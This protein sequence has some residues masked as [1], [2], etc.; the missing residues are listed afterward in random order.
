M[1]HI[2]ARPQN[3]VA[4]E[5]IDDERAWGRQSGPCCSCH[6]PRV[7]LSTSSPPGDH[8]GQ[9]EHDD[10]N[11]RVQSQWPVRPGGA[12]LDSVD[13]LKQPP[14]HALPYVVD[15]SVPALSQLCASMPPL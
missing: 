15:G 3:E 14:I 4:D 6:S 2:G 7:T 13:P 1:G 10:A 11:P 9:R 12:L 8:D 5:L